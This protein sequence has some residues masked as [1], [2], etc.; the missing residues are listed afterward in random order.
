MNK[1]I[2]LAALILTA[3]LTFTA[4]TFINDVLGINSPDS[5]TTDEQTTTDTSNDP[6]ITID[7][8]TGETT[9]SNSNAEGGNSDI[10]NYIEVT[11]AEDKYFYENHEISYDD[12]IKV[13]DEL[14]ENTA[15]KLNDENATL[16]AYESLTN[17]LE[18][19][20]IMIIEA[21]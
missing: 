8:T 2:A 6:E 7:T 12:L 14:D 18:E 15:V 21:S 16:K 1:K 4:C 20:G 3:S 17:A 10:A 19:R 13:F 5:Q 11:V 9:D